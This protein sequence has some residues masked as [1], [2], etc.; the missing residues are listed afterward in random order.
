MSSHRMICRTVLIV[1]IALLMSEVAFTQSVATVGALRQVMHA[2]NLSGQVQLDTL[3][4]KYHYGLGP[5]AY[6]RGEIFL[7]NDTT[8]V[9]RVSN[10][11]QNVVAVEPAVTAPFLVYTSLPA[12]AK[13]IP[14]DR[15]VSNLT[16][17][18]TLVE[19]QAE[20]AGQSLD[21]PFAFTLVG[22]AERIVYHVMNR[23]VNE[24][25]HSPA[26]HKKSKQFYS[27]SQE[28]VL[29]LGF[30]SRHHQ[31]V[32]THHDAYIHVHV[33]N[34]ARTKMGHLDEITTVPSALVIQ[35][36]E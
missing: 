34:G 19:E 10:E 3:P 15:R 6:L 22:K 25:G 5:V 2:G 18:Q 23:P 28:D 20:A 29:L 30:Y 1:G 35:F 14:I 31:G 36:T 33:I 11:Q 13:G 7:W 24:V 27:M 32:F 17:L 8:Y 9:S 12:W 26:L 21:K 4:G 16:Q